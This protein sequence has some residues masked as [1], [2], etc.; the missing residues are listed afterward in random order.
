MLSAELTINFCSDLTFIFCFELKQIHFLKCPMKSNLWL[1]IVHLQAHRIMAQHR[2]SS[3]LLRFIRAVWGTGR[4]Q[5]INGV[6]FPVKLA[7][8]TIAGGSNLTKPQPSRVNMR[9]CWLVYGEGVLCTVNPMRAPYVLTQ[10]G[11]KL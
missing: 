11:D 4:E 9:M 5:E 7:S 6:L 2:V 10:R 1:F 8:E 3:V